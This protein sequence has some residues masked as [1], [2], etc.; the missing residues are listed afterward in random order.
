L[1]KVRKTNDEGA[2]II[3]VEGKTREEQ[4]RKRLQQRRQ[5]LNKMRR[6]LK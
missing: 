4:E 6:K 5:K 2:Q 3:Q 1:K